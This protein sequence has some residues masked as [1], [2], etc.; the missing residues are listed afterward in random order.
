VS[1]PTRTT[2]FQRSSP[3]WSSFQTF[4]A[5]TGHAP[6]K[7]L[8]EL[9]A[10]RAEFLSR[11]FSRERPVGLTATASAAELFSAFAEAASRER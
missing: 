4:G 3:A 5:A 7:A 6:D 11:L 8:M 1:G 10:D 9:S 2:T